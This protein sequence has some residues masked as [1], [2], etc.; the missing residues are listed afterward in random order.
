MLRPKRFLSLKWR[1][2]LS[3]SLS[4]QLGPN[5]HPPADLLGLQQGRRRPAPLH[6]PHPGY[7]SCGWSLPSITLKH[8]CSLPASMSLLGHGCLSYFALPLALTWVKNRVPHG[9]QPRTLGYTPHAW[10]ACGFRL[11]LEVVAVPVRQE[12]LVS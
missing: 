3:Q 10:L 2:T 8:Y 5:G 12:Q 9:F 7:T 4:A 6:T 1:S 11:L